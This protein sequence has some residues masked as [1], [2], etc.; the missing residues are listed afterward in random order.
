ML[1]PL[2]KVIRP[3]LLHARHYSSK[4]ASTLNSSLIF[5]LLLITF[6][7]SGSVLA[8]FSFPLSESFTG[9]SAPGWVLG[10]TTILTSGNGDPAGNGWLRLTS[11][12]TYQAGY[13]YFNT[14]I[15]TGDGLIV[16]FDYAAWG[17]NG[18]DGLTFFLFDGATTTFNIGASGGSLG[19]AQKTGTKG[20]SN[21]YLGLG[22]DEF[23]NYSNPNEGRS[24]GPGFIPQAIVIRGPGS[25]TV[26]YSYQKGTTSLNKTP[27][28][29]PRIDC[30]QNTGSCGTGA[31][32]PASSV[33]YRKVQITLTPIGA[34]FEVSVSMKFSE[35]GAW[36]QLLAPYT[37]PT[38]APGT[39]KL[40]FSG[41]T[42]GQTNYHE[43]RNLAVTQQVPDLTVTKAVE[44]AST[45]GGSVSAGD[46][47]LYTMVF[48]N[49]TDTSIGNVHFIDNIPANTTY[50]T[51]SANVPTGSTLNTTDPIDIT[52]I[53]V[54]NHGQ[55]T[56]TFKVRVNDPLPSSVTK[57]SNQ[58]TYSYNSGTITSQTDGDAVTTGNQP[59]TIGVTLG[60]NFD[61]STKLVSYEDLD[62]NDAVS[63]ADRLTY[64]VVLPNT[65]NQD[66]AATSFL[67]T[68]PDN[69]TYVAGSAAV[70]AGTV[71]Y[72]STARKLTWTVSVG[73]GTQETLDFKV[74]VN[75]GVKIRDLISNQGSITSN[76]TTILTDADLALPG[77]QPTQLLVGGS[78]TL[79]AIKT[80]SVLSPP[81]KPGGELEYTIQL[82][83][84]SSYAI[85]GATFVDT[86]PTNTTYI[87]NSATT[88]AGTALYTSPALSITGINLAGSES[89]TITFRVQINTP[90]PAGVNQI[91][92]Q[93]LANWDSNNSGAN[94]ASLQTDGNLDSAGQQ[95][96][97]T[98]IETADLA[99]TKSVD[100]AN[101]A[102]TGTINYSVKVTNHGPG[103]ASLVEVND[104]L[105]PGLS[106]ASSSATQGSYTNPTWSVGTLASGTSATLSITASVDS[107]MGGRTIVNTASAASAYHDDNT[108]N[109]TASVTLVVGTTS[110]TGLVTDKDSGAPLANVSMQVTDNN[111]HTCTTTTDV[112]GSYTFT[113]GVEG[114]LLDPGTAAVEANAEGYLPKSISKTILAG[115]INTQNFEMVRPSLNGM[116]TDLGTG[117]PIAG[118]TVTLTQGATIC[119]TTTGAGG[120]YNFTAGTEAPACNFTTGSV[121]VT[122]SLT[123]YEPDTKTTIILSSGA[124]TLNLAL[125]TVD[126]LITKT[127][128]RKV[129]EPG[130]NLS[131]EITVTNT[132]SIDAPGVVIEDLPV[133]GLLYVSDTAS[134]AGLTRTVPD[135]EEGL[136]QWTTP[137][138]AS[139]DSITFNLVMQVSNSLPNGTSSLINYA[140]AGTT[141]VEKNHTNNDVTDIDTVNAQPDLTIYK[142]FTSPPPA[143]LGST[144]TYKLTGKNDGHA[145]ATQVS[146]IDTLDPSTTYTTGT[147]EL[148]INGSPHLF[149]SESYNSGSKTLTLTLPD[150]DPA[151]SYEITYPVEVFTLAGNPPSLINT[152]TITAAEV[153]TSNSNNTSSVGV[154]TA[155]N[156]DVG[157][158]KSA[159][160]NSNSPKP[161]DQITYTL[162]YRNDGSNAAE[163]VTIT[164]DVPANTSLVSGS[165]TGGGLESGDTIT[166]NL[167]TINSQESGSVGFTVT[168]DNLLPAG[169][170]A[171]T[172][173]AAIGTT[174]D[175]VVSTNDNSSV[176]TALSA[177]PD[178]V[179]T[180]SDGRTQVLP[181]DAV[182]YFI[183]YLNSGNQTAE[184]VT[185]VD[186]LLNGL[187]IDETQ[188]TGTTYNGS[189]PASTYNSAAGTLTWNIGTLGADGSH[190]ISI[191]LIVDAATTANSVVANRITISD[192]AANGE[193]PNPGNNT[194][195]DSDLVAAPY[196]T[197]EKSV[198]GTVYFGEKI[199]YGI[200]WTNV[201]SAAAESITIQD[202]LP[203]HTTL[204]AGSITSGGLYDPDT[205]TITWDLGTQTVGA[206]GTVNFSLIAGVDAGGSTSPAATLSTE[207]NSGSIHVTSSTTPLDL[208]WCEGNRCNSFKGIYQGTDGTTTPGWNDNPRLSTFGE[209]GWTP[210]IAA[211]TEEL[212]YWTN[213]NNLS[214]EWVAM[215]TA[216][217]KE[218]NF[219]F[220]RQAFCLP[221][222]AIGLNGSLQLAGDDV[223]N[224]TLNGVY[225]GKQIGAG[226]ANTFNAGSGIQSGI[227]VLAVQ[228]LNNRHNGHPL[229]DGGDHSGLLFNL[230]AAFTGLRPFASAPNAVPAGQAVTFQIDESAL[231]GQTPFEYKI[232]YG[233]GVTAD[234]Q[235]GDTFTHTYAN[236][237]T[238]HA[239]LTA[240]AGYGCTGTDLV[241]VTVL[242]AASTLLANLATVNY[243]DAQAHI[244]SGQSGFGSELT[245]A[246]DLS[247]SKTIK[248]G[249]ETPGG[250]VSY[251]VVVTNLG[252]NSVSGAAV[253]DEIPENIRNVSWTCTAEGGGT[254]AHISGSGSEL[255]ETVDLPLDATATYTIT[256]TI[257]TAATG[258]LSNTAVVTSPADIEDLTQTNN[259]SEVVSTLVPN[260][261][262]A[263]T[264]VSSPNPGLAPGYH[265]TYTIVV[266][267]N[268]S[269]DAVG[270]TVTDILPPELT[271]VAWT[272]SASNG[273]TCSRSGSGDINDT[274]TILGGGSLTYTVRAVVN[275]ASP[276]DTVISNTAA[277]QFDE[278]TESASDL[279]PLV[280][281]TVL[282][283]TDDALNTAGISSRMEP[284][285][286]ADHS[287]GISP[288]DTLRYKVVVSNGPDTAYLVTYATSMDIHTT[289]KAG[290]V[291]CEPPCTVNQGNTGGDT[292]VDASLGSIAPFGSVTIYYEAEVNADLP[293]QLTTLSNQGF[294]GSSN[295]PATATDDPLTTLV[296]GDETTVTLTLS[297][298]GGAV[299][300]DDDGDGAMDASE[301]RMAR[302][303][304]TLYYA[305][306]DGIFNNSDDQ[307]MVDT[308]E[309]DGSFIFT[310][311]SA[312]RYKAGFIAPAMYKFSPPG[313]D[314]DVDQDGFTDIIVL[315]NYTQLNTEIGIG[316]EPDNT[317]F[318]MNFGHLPAAYTGLNIRADGGAWSLTGNT[319]LGELVTTALEGINSK[320]YTVKDSDDGISWTE[321]W[322][323][324]TGTA[325]IIAVCPDIG[326]QRDLYAWFDWNNDRDFEDA[327]EMDHWK[328]SC[329]PGG[330]SGTIHFTYPNSV[331]KK[332][333]LS[334]GTYY[335]RFRIYDAEPANP[336][337]SGAALTETSAYMVGEI[338]DPFITIDG[339]Q[340]SDNLP[341]DLPSTGF[342]YGKITQL[343]KQPA[344]KLYSA[345]DLMLNIP[346]LGINSPILGIPQSESSWDVSWLG[347]NIGYMYGSAYPTWAGNT[348]LTG[349]VWNAD[350]SPG[351]FVN[352][353]NL[354]YGDQITIHNL[355]QVYTYEV[356]ENK[357]VHGNSVS[358]V[359]QSERYSWVTLLT[360]ENY[361]EASD[362]YQYR[363]MVR[364]VLVKVE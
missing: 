11:K 107:G 94:N 274:V 88:T 135:P 208:P 171:I 23:G 331:S 242:P 190:N 55:A 36:V 83:N 335:T 272:C 61:T 250:N 217:E 284:F 58:G 189:T 93:G 239:S 111:S 244:Y 339:G 203:D 213:P 118:A 191:D 128:L 49:H 98:D 45:N 305:G 158:Y 356:R 206:S 241:K 214:A 168:I 12:S 210:P 8:A 18:A 122:A 308:V 271:Y 194:D 133:S 307:V 78:A 319:H 145:A 17:G 131:Y 146:I 228:L 261:V 114:C 204:V 291:S 280:S 172:N 333:K 32:R 166:W 50:V 117:V 65:G 361:M 223:S 273:S 113:S 292:A 315:N 68:L 136:Y 327:E 130:Q 313:V 257:D 269:S 256:G 75:T 279:N 69:V 84:T 7:P 193:D 43:I 72:N 38:S 359:F 169:T 364:A 25:G 263:I 80:A 328:V 157:I 258:S 82:T 30:P 15:P 224:I 240:R 103:A 197:L 123:G 309:A 127:D 182:T 289:L 348:V 112:N 353:K 277:V 106:L 207:S 108:V 1:Y 233:D 330:V 161:G 225:V 310:N 245:P 199:E 285:I 121:S 60:P 126:L 354:K 186:T 183:T 54:P 345:T 150:L 220:F 142:V 21:G 105:P 266:T 195:T 116:V 350:N 341:D 221:L 232:D 297:M 178:L 92:N 56:I 159:I 249:G 317:I 332:G 152:A 363:R 109:N 296:A 154:P 67:D 349:H 28:N 71:T 95:P 33:Y 46:E 125:G 44:N 342:S 129:V 149:S 100:D 202:T 164:D 89:A 181:G 343:P 321:D 360:C 173:S 141:G 151:D 278:T 13:A 218:G 236:P 323:D 238:Y 144:I 97:L 215:H 91:S 27:F 138:L 174:S 336:A 52:G 358:S 51:N 2:V 229:F 70:S 264:K 176:I 196:I 314:N 143:S 243:L 326:G 260:V 281:A 324:N 253:V 160:V 76:S 85:S 318:R 230:G 192:D 209:P 234:Y 26:G 235:A 124:T 16:T 99:V 295:A 104:T 288:G 137:S 155:N 275:P 351:V 14:P 162:D 187:L 175:D 119:T 9:S 322:V 62:G 254:C 216:A 222:N 19:Y 227:N 81:L 219:T 340:I 231:G 184:G 86:I 325:T 320:T 79:T 294:I 246:A 115:V 344:E 57:I 101:P 102:E 48:S 265:V 237:G 29:L 139:G 276:A 282:T 42:G 198:S 334:K 153:E 185:I 35:S 247:I 352:I 90:L 298:I 180:K 132:G 134:A 362:A 283:A 63:A 66:A 77:K 268:G 177:Q 5:I 47:L 59:T 165:I 346:S 304:V 201:G 290:S 299:W 312:G 31:A 293:F 337:S 262:P 303:P 179:I 267:N 147:A 74:A 211:S 39:L 167:G 252:P 37:L 87:A 347:E 251:Q 259:S 53:T 24:G 300:R 6:A 140:K 163:S 34:A 311:L 170:S 355:G 301:P 329:G 110:L 22:L 248:T 20:L 96:T 286:D 40:G 200:H 212:S 120:T 10:G 338:E 302:V 287:G 188:L 64:R 4:F 255:N 156:T 316:L 226:S 306:P 205:R 148:K 73:A 357:L 270:A 3:I 41:S